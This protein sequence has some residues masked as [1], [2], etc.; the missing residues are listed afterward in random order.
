MKIFRNTLGGSGRALPSTGQMSPK[1]PDRLPASAL[2]GLMS[3][4]R[5]LDDGQGRCAITFDGRLDGL[6]IARAVV[7]SLDA[8][9][10]LDC[11][12]VLHPWRHRWER[13][14]LSD[15]VIPFLQIQAQDSEREIHGFLA[16]SMDAMRGP[17]VAVRL[18]RSDRDVLCVK[19]H[20]MVADARGLLDYIRLLRD[21]YRQLQ[22]HPDF[23]P[24]AAPAGSRGQGQILRGAGLRAV[25][26]GC[27]SF[28]FPRP[29]K[30]FPRTGTDMSG[31]A[32]AIRR[33]SSE[34]GAR[35]KA[36]C[37]T[38]RVKFTDVLVTAFYRA[39]FRV[40]N[41]PAGACL[42][43]ELTVDLR[44]YLPSGRA[45]TVCD[46]AGAY[47]PVIRHRPEASFDQTLGEVQTA[48]AKAKAGHAWLGE[49]LSLELAFLLP[50]GITTRLGQKIIER[51]LHAGEAYPVFSNLGVIDPGTFDFGD[52]VA[53][54][55]GVFGPVMFP[56][57]FLISI[58]SFRD[59]LS[60][61]SSFCDTAADPL[62]VDTFLTNFM[63]ELPA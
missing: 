7:L 2:D 18:I 53:V 41:P 23:I 13:R 60:I 36:Y 5:P 63:N 1:L 43:V 27:L 4:V 15:R 46:L 9:P 42:P 61:T 3:V 17:Q 50:A 59:Q 44:R 6:Q 12:Y 24:P 48:I 40:L 45:N 11:R 20:H 52:A 56:P 22:I 25:I 62:L 47:F 26:Q 54:D 49:A 57:S 31:R 21:L 14:S 16:E 39:L 10:I 38:K 8:A 34:R 29:P 37:R 33:I 19:L 55:L 32:F 35:L 51:N 28:R 30:G 58:H